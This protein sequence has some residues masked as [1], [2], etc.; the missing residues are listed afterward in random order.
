MICF[1]FTTGISKDRASRVA[2][3]YA[4]TAEARPE[5]RGGVKTFLRTTTGRQVCVM[6][7]SMYANQYCLSWHV[8]WML[9]TSMFLSYLGWHFERLYLR[10]WLC[11]ILYVSYFELFI[12]CCGQWCYCYRFNI[13]MYFYQCW[14]LLF[15]KLLLFS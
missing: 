6:V 7:K 4:E 15:S 5:R 12:L 1:Y 13:C 2:W 10:L 8:L 11:T 3:Y 9:P 14:L